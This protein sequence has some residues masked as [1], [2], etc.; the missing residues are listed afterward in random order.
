[1]PEP[2][3]VPPGYAPLVNPAGELKYYPE[4][5]VKENI[6]LYGYKIPTDED[7]NKAALKKQYGE[8]FGNELAAAIEGAASGA[9]FGISRHAENIL[10]ITTPEAQAAR[11]EFN[12][13]A[14]GVGE[15][16]GII[17]S[18]ALLPGA[19]LPGLLERG[20]MKAGAK[21]VGAGIAEKAVPAMIGNRVAQ[22]ILG[23]G[24]EKL[25]ANTVGRALEG[26]VYGAAQPISES[27]LGDPTITAQKVFSQIGIGGL[28][29]GGV[30]AATSL[31]GIGAGRLFKKAEAEIAP[32]ISGAGEKFE[33]FR[34]TSSKGPNDFGVAGKGKYYS[35]DPRVAAAYAGTDGTVEKA[36]VE[37]SN[38]LKMTYPELNKLQTE[39][40]GKPLTGFEK[41]LS[42]KFDSYLREKGYDGVVLFDSEISSSI[43]QEVVKLED[44]VTSGIKPT[45][46]QTKI[47][48]VLTTEETSVRPKDVQYYQERAAKKVIDP[49]TG[50]EV[51]ALEASP[52]LHPN[53][54][55]PQERTL[56]NEMANAY[57][58]NN[59]AVKEA[60]QRA[61]D[62]LTGEVDEAGNVLR[63]PPNIAKPTAELAGIFEKRIGEL[64]GMKFKG[65]ETLT[66][67]KKLKTK[68]GQLV[69]KVDDE[70][71]VIWE[72]PKEFNA[73]ELK[74]MI[75]EFDKDLEGVYSR[76]IGK[77]M[78]ETE[79][80][81]VQL[82]REIS[83]SLKKE[84]KDAG[85]PEYSELMDEMHRRLGVGSNWDKY[86]SANNS[87]NSRI[88]GALQ[89]EVEDV[90]TVKALT[91]KGAQSD[92]S[93]LRAIHDLGEVTGK[94]FRQMYKDRYIWAKFHEAEASYPEK[95]SAFSQLLKNTF[96]AVRNPTEIPGKLGEAVMDAPEMLKN[97][98]KRKAME[99]LVGKG[100]VDS[101]AVNS[102][103]GMIKGGAKSG[104][105]LFDPSG[106][107]GSYMVP[108]GVKFQQYLD[109]H[110]NLE[111]AH[112]QLE[113]LTGLEKA[114]QKADKAIDVA[115]SGIFSGSASPKV[116]Y[117]DFIG[118][119]STEKADDLEK[120]AAD[121]AQLAND[122]SLLVEKLS[123]GLQG[124]GEH[125]PNITTG[126][127]MTASRA[128]QFLSQKI[129]GLLP[130]DQKM[131]LD[132][133]HVP[134]KMQ[135]VSLA[136][137]LKYINAPYEVLK[138]LPSGMVSK[139][140]KEV[141]VSVYP[142]LYNELKGRVM[143]GIAEQQAKGK[144]IP[145]SKRLGLSFFL[146]QNLDSTI[147]PMSLQ[148]NQAAFMMPQ[149]QS[150]RPPTSKPD[151]V[152]RMMSG[153]QKI[154]SRM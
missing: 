118:K 46:E 115:I 17:G 120:I 8:G 149:P 114:Q 3:T 50:K 61:R 123:E 25:A 144:A 49:L 150:Q 136:K 18:M 9:T 141:L 53:P 58:E 40:Y 30:G 152:G 94:D 27:A 96:R 72:A 105:K 33:V 5:S 19:S 74:K 29:G 2:L 128:V 153:T 99:A 98:Q 125:A 38:P 100:S 110:D 73:Q 148:A 130:Q 44:V 67:I 138:E 16:G 127:N 109:T 106:P 11:K 93:W 111:S 83:D 31:L 41:D 154:A 78:T 151:A 48:Q 142:E 28:I 89:R 22:E 76:K 34:G 87:Y 146:D 52:R 57:E 37:L 122:P 116:S 133:K 92:V 54:Q 4:A 117:A 145:T 43:P 55:N 132:K 124:I 21:I 77:G 91:K 10:G 63:P 13:M 143:N 14:S 12:P 47:A 56:F 103:L 26:M 32:E 24:I 59:Q 23:T 70:G 82:R 42:S 126:L 68:L 66:A 147:K 102:I 80:Q 15:V 1:V 85:F 101:G 95:G 121:T 79:S 86:F 62:L 39:L 134:S 104:S 113:V 75:Q 119:S 108:A 90:Q 137:T 139:E 64:E 35:G 7:L 107:M 88:L 131:P 84:M 135:L 71:N 20:A 140:G 60:G 129:G 112:T 65:D 36:T 97:L 69:D 51:N 81:L 45:P 6:D